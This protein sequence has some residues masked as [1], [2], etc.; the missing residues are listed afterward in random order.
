MIVEVYS[1]PDCLICETI[2]NLLLEKKI[3][4]T[5]VYD[6]QARTRAIQIDKCVKETISCLFV[7]NQRKVALQKSRQP[8]STPYPLVFKDDIYIPNNVLQNYD[9]FSSDIYINNFPPIIVYG[10]GSSCF[11]CYQTKK[12]LESKSLKYTYIDTLLHPNADPNPRKCENQIFTSFPKIII[13]STCIGGYDELKQLNKKGKLNVFTSKTNTSKEPIKPI[14]TLLSTSQNLITNTESMTFQKSLQVVSKQTM[15]KMN[16]ILQSSDDPYLQDIAKFHSWRNFKTVL[17]LQTAP[18]T[19]LMTPDAKPFATLVIEA[20]CPPLLLEEMIR[21]GLQLDATMPG[22]QITTRDYILNIC[23]DIATREL[24]EKYQAHQHIDVDTPAFNSEIEEAR[25]QTLKSLKQ[26]EGNWARSE[27]VSLIETLAY[28][29]T[30]GVTQGLVSFLIA[31]IT[32]Y[33]EKRFPQNSLLKFWLPHILSAIVQSALS[34]IR[35]PILEKT[36]WQDEEESQDSRKMIEALSTYFFSAL[37]TGIAMNMAITKTKHFI[38][39]KYGTTARTG[40]VLNF[41]L[42]YL[43]A[44]AN[45]P[46]LLLSQSTYTNQA[47]ALS[48]FFVNL[49]TRGTTFASVKWLREKC[50]LSAQSAPNVLHEMQTL[51]QDPIQDPIYENT[52]LLDQENTITR[53]FPT[54]E[55]I[56]VPI[57]N[58]HILFSNTNP[59]DQNQQN[60][61]SLKSKFTAQNSHLFHSLQQSELKQVFEK[62]VN[63]SNNVYPT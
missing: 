1:L 12:L 36:F 5:L 43:A 59:Q 38:E 14:I 13:N 33:L 47:I 3:L 8:V 32:Q 50:C 39:N 27:H 30:E 56:R 10:R 57:N 48:G 42:P 40:K 45:L 55:T 17:D 31:E 25:L 22:Y 49:A 24:L 29:S 34:L 19:E 63:K 20:K 21:R 35:Y 23:T 62:Y 4:Y 7:P 11:N 51:K 58:K 6:V 41:M 9:F 52:T 28:Q 26:Q 2:E 18:I 46:S 54:L 53:K 60:P 61:I 44:L 37:A 15:K 16:N